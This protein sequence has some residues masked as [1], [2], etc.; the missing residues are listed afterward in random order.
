MSPVPF[1]R[2]RRRYRKMDLGFLDLG[3]LAKPRPIVAVESNINH[4]RGRTDPPLFKNFLPQSFC[5]EDPPGSNAHE[6][7]LQ[8]I[9]HKFDRGRPRSPSLSG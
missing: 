3:G 9:D 4:S 8:A 6:D 7:V 1:Q 2:N 5:Q